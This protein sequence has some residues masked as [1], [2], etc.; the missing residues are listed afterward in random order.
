M[1]HLHRSAQ[2]CFFVLSGRVTMQV[3]HLEI[4]LPAGEGLPILPMVRQRI[5][6]QSEESARFLVISQP[7]RY[8]DCVVRKRWDLDASALIK[9]DTVVW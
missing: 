7:P 2:Q 3:E 4:R 5:S 6:N 8:S 1:L 9:G